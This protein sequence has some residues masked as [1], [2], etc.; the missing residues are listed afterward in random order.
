VGL[1][2]G[3]GGAM[4]QNDKPK[5]VLIISALDYW[6]MGEGKGGPALYKTLIGY[7]ERGWKVY[8]ITGNRAQGTPDNLHENIQVIRFDVPWLKRL[9]QIKKIVFFAKILWWVYFQIRAFIEAQRLQSKE[10]MDVVYGY[11]IYGVPVAKLLSKLWGVPVIARFQGTSL[12]V[13]WVKR[14]LWKLRAWEHILGLRIPVDLVIMT[15]DGT[16]GDRVL[17]SLGVNMERVRFWMNGVDWELFKSLPEKAEVSKYL[18]VS[19]CK[20][21]L[22]VSRLVRWKR[23]DRAIQALPEVVRSF[24]DTILLIVGD[25]PERKRLE[26]LAKDLGVEKYVRFEGAVPHKEVPKYLAAADIFLSFYDWSNVGNPLLEAMMAG[27]C[28]IT[29]NNGDTG[30]FIKNGENGILLEYEDLPKL[31]EVIKELLANEDL[32]NRLGASAWKFAEEHF[33]SWQERIEAEI[34]EVGQLIEQ[35]KKKSY[36]NK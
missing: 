15:N 8:F 18:Q 16:Q 6:S 5:S 21:L 23:V 14:P 36:A 10:K 11:E 13:D 28:I 12:G 3:E 34:A 20:V 7:A 22:T 4:N 33:W 31:P 25:G 17:K 24:P 30:Q 9:I 27:K 35:R 32:R 2:Q 29:L 19:G 1:G 26:Q